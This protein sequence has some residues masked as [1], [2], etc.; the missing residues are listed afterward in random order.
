VDCPSFAREYGITQGSHGSELS[1]QV[2][3]LGALLG[4]LISTYGAFPRDR[5]RPGG[6]TNAANR[7]P[8]PPVPRHFNHNPKCQSHV[9]GFPEAR[10]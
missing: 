2:G 3:L 1:S 7:K 4:E 9:Q 10:V 8:E 6:T 5:A